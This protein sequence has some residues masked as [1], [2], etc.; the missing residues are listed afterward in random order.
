MAVFRRT[1]AIIKE[2]REVREEGEKKGGV[3][4]YCFAFANGFLRQLRR[5]CHASLK[6]FA[7][8]GA[9]EG[10][11][12]LQYVLDSYHKAGSG[13]FTNEQ[14]EVAY[15]DYLANRSPW[16]EAFLTKNANT[17]HKEGAVLSAEVPANV[18]GAACIAGR[19]LWEYSYSIKAFNDLV[20]KDMKESVAFL[21]CLSLHR[22]ELDKDK[23]HIITCGEN[24][25]VVTQELGVGGGYKNFLDDN[26]ITRRTL[27]KE[28]GDYYGINSMF[29]DNKINGQI[30]LREGLIAILGSTAKKEGD[31]WGVSCKASYKEVIEK[32]SS[33]K[34]KVE[35]LLRGEEYE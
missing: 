35:A 11:V 4:N 34:D 22:T 17:I 18:V 12:D 29:S 20:E 24:H 32:L 10:L 27:L 1:N 30:S 25:M 13:C 9:R 26:I 5:P 15:I 23:V 3:S 28:N 8:E 2:M 31:G 19:Q 16:R 21:V 7:S 33:K 14:E 6:R